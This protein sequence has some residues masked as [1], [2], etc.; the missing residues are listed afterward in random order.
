MDRSY[1]LW[2]RSLQ[3]RT[4]FSSRTIVEGLDLRPCS[5]FIEKL[6]LLHIIYYIGVWKLIDD[7]PLWI[8]YYGNIDRRRRIIYGSWDHW[9]ISASRFKICHEFPFVGSKEWFSFCNRW[10]YIRYSRLYC[11]RIF[12]FGIILH[13]I[14]LLS[15]FYY[16]VLLLHGFYRWKFHNIYKA[17]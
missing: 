7:Y 2:F 13:L 14:L 5:F 16:Y 10:L 1:T 3:I 9:I 17:L 4:H 11:L 6:F 8:Q 12:L 15:G